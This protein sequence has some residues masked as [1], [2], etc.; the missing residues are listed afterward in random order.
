[1]KIRR[2]T[3]WG[4]LDDVEAE[5]SGIIRVLGWAEGCDSPAPP[6]VR[7]ADKAIPLLQ[8][9]RTTRP[10]LPISDGRFAPQAG[11]VFEYLVPDDLRGRD[12]SPLVVAWP[13]LRRPLRWKGAF[14]FLTPHYRQ[15]QDT[16]EVMRRE[17]IYGSGPPAAEVT[18]ELARLAEYLEGRVLDFG[19]GRGAMVAYLRS[20]GFDALGLELERDGLRDLIAPET[21][22]FVT[23]Y[24]GSFPIPFRDRSFDCVFA[25]EVLE[26]VPRFDQAIAE[27]ARVARRRA[28]LTVPDASAIP[29]GY[30]H[31]LVPWH[32]LESTHIHFFTQASLARA[33]APHFSKVEFGRI[34]PYR[35]NDSP[36]YLSLVAVCTVS[37]DANGS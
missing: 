34:S 15:L 8:S 35:I 16:A 36:F 21:R 18:P 20:K 7:L 11:I 9:Y 28:V 29:L 19:C 25:S 10:D 37:A 22:P 24:D 26:H 31:Q 32:L 30:R 33:L 13:G 2:R 27:M 12:L 4:Y 17:Q 1:M 14:R 6:E 5:P 23:L 3:Q